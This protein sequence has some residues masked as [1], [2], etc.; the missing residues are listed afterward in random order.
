[1]SSAFPAKLAI[2]NA[3]LGLPS[4]VVFYGIPGVGKTSLGAMTPRPIF[5]MTRGET[6]L[7][8]LLDNGL[9]PP[10]DHFPEITDWLTLLQA[11]DLLLIE[12]TG[13]KTFVLDALNGA[14]RLC[15]EHVVAT[16]YSG[17]WE[18]FLAYGKGPEAAV[19]EWTKLIGLLHK[20]NQ[21][22]RMA[23]VLLA[24]CKIKTFKNP[25]GEDY[26]RYS[27]EMH[28]KIWGP[29][30]KW[31]DMVLFGN[32]Q[33]YAKK[34]Y[35]ALRAKAFDNDERVFHTRRRAAFDAKNRIGLPPEIS[36][37]KSA[38]EAWRNLSSEIKKARQSQLEA[39]GTADGE[40][41]APAGDAGE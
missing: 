17:N 3:G 18:K 41:D 7:L 1:M 16:A 6:G 23:I 8:T 19:A 30:D 38:A 20:L 21:Q 26:D 15:F 22:R 32:Y 36:M 31:A 4:K 12:K 25:E 14:E 10:T 28:E 9:V 5:A 24:H 27:T 34:D 40:A 37:G 29:V 2:S 35:G 39:N 11:V 33:T 13:H